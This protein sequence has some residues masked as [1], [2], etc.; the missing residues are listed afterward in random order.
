V[1]NPTEK[2]SSLLVQNRKLD[3]GN[4]NPGNIG[5]DFNPLGLAF[6]EEVR[7][8]DPRN[9][10]RQTLLEELNAWRNAIAHQDFAKVAPTPF[11]R[12]SRVTRWRTACDRLAS[13]FDDVMRSHIQSIAGLAPW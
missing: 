9:L 5:A 13:A 10:S 3:K 11:L 2:R 1:R 8:S 4:A 6:W 12:L 7:R